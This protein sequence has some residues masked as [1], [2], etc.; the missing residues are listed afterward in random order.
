M[1]LS[2][3]P[4]SRYQAPLVIPEDVP[5]YRLRSAFFGPDDCLYAEGDVIVLED[6]PNQEMIPL[7]KLAKKNMKAYLEK[8][9]DDGRK[10]AEKLGR[11]FVS[12]ADAH[13]NAMALEKEESKRVTLLNGKPKGVPL[14]GADKKNAAKRVTKLQAEAEAVPMARGKM[15]LANVARAVN[16]NTDDKAEDLA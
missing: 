11:N 15:A 5:V 9:D 4:P 14:M 6:E 7:N 16:G 13:E 10:V 8:L 3:T 1:Q 2:P 12:I